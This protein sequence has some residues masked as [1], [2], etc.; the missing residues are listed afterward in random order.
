MRTR[1]FRRTALTLAALF[2]LAVLLAV[3]IQFAHAGHHCADGHCPLCVA[4]T[5]SQLA[6]RALGAVALTRALAL[7]ARVAPPVLPGERA[8]GAAGA[9]LVSLNI[10]MND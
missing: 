4:Y 9:S 10:R 8:F 6:F 5:A 7:L 2:A 1:T 3:G